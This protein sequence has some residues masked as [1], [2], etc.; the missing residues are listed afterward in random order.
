MNINT[1]KW[2]FLLISLLLIG[3]CEKD[4]IED[5][6]DECM[7]NCDT[8]P[9][10]LIHWESPFLTGSDPT[11][12][13][14]FI[15]GPVI[16][17]NVV[18]YVSLDGMGGESQKINFF[19]YNRFNGNEEWKTDIL[20]SE[21]GYTFRKIISVE[22]Q[23]IVFGLWKFLNISATDG[24]VKAQRNTD[25]FPDGYAHKTIV[26]DQIYFTSETTK[27]N[28]HYTEVITYDLHFENW[29]TITTIKED[30][31]PGPGSQFFKGKNYFKNENDDL[32]GI[33]MNQ[34][35]GDGFYRSSVL[36]LNLSS[37]STY[38]DRLLWKQDLQSVKD[39]G[40]YRTQQVYSDSLLIIVGRREIFGVDLNVGILAYKVIIEPMIRGEFLNYPMIGN[41]I[42]LRDLHLKARIMDVRTG[43]KAGEMNGIDIP[44]SGIETYNGLFY[45]VNM[46]R[47]M[48]LNPES[49]EVV[50]SFTPQ[51]RSSEI[52]DNHFPN[53]NG[54]AID[55]ENK[56]L[57]TT[58]NWYA[59]C[60]E[61]P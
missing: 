19:A 28:K 24:S 9:N 5:H 29:K 15:G 27:Q 39:F 14:L 25:D 1:I 51:K 17:G 52:F 34:Y 50:W 4:K 36:A 58:D 31:P 10:E 3:A 18:V 45:F 21:L 47:L 23:I 49:L 37:G 13:K 35:A 12:P 30:T 57:Y 61:L 32:I 46:K 42:L 53:G 20:S 44:A 38:E 6:E 26:G 55:T 43:E 2:L 11:I 54:I 41:K 56:L 7:V 59:L 33:Y 48:S 22:D 8:L 40:L 60:I 16:A